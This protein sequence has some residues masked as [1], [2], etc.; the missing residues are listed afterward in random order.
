MHNF[1]RS[2]LVFRKNVEWLIAAIVFFSVA[3][4]GY[5]QCKVIKE[6]FTKIN[7][8]FKAPTPGVMFWHMG[9]YAPFI[10]KYML[11]TF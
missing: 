1:S 11:D 7:Q 5:V 9:A 3:L 4:L 2:F 6:A 10:L 8:V